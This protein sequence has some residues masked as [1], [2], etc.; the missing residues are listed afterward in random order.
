MLWIKRVNASPF[1]DDVNKWELGLI[2]NF[3]PILLLILETIR[4]MAMIVVRTLIA[5]LTE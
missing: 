2:S 3:R 1:S 5:S 4:V